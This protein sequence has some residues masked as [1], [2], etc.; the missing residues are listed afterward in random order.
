[1]RTVDPVIRTY[2]RAERVSDGVVHVMGVLAA[3]AAV[4]VLITLA[5]VWNAGG[6]GV[7]AVSVY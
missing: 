7:G 1:M 6:L 5:M 2:S 4:P 3:L